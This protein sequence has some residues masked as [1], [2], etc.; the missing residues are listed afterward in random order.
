MFLHTLDI[1][2]IDSGYVTWTPPNTLET[3]GE[4]LE[5]TLCYTLTEGIAVLHEV[6]NDKS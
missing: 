4:S 2:N 5:E 1:S 3:Y 6:S